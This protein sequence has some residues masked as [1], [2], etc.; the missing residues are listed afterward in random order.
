MTIDDPEL[1]EEFLNEAREHLELVES[2]LL[3]LETAEGD[4]KP[5]LNTIFR[6]MHSIKGAAGMLGFDQMRDLTHA[7]E[8]VLSRLR[9]GTQETDPEIVSALLTATDSVKGM[10]ENI[11]GEPSSDISTE[12]A[13]LEALDPSRRAT[14]A[15]TPEP[16]EPAPEPEPES[17]PEPAPESTPEPD[18]T[19][20]D[21][22]PADATPATVADS[23]PSPAPAANDAGTPANAAK[24]GARPAGA[25]GGAQQ[26]V[27]GQ[28][29]NETVRVPVWV[30]D[31]LMALT[32]ELVLVRNRTLQ[33][34]DGQLRRDRSL[35]GSVD[36]R[37]AQQ[38]DLVT[39]DLQEAVLRTR[40]QPVGKVFSRIPRLC[41]DLA[42][43]LDKQ[44]SCVTLGDDVEVDKTILE[45]LSDP[46]IHLVRNACDHGLETPDER[47][48]TGKSH[49]GVVQIAAR[50]DAGQI[51]ITIKD[52]GRGIDPK[53]IGAKAI[54]VGLCRPDEIAAMT[55]KQI[56]NLIFAPGFSTA[57]EVGAISGRGVG[58]DVVK[59]SIEGIGGSL[60]VVSEVGRGSTFHLRVPLTL[61]IVSSLV[62]RT[63]GK[64]FAIPQVNLEE[65]VRLDDEEISEGIE[66]VN[67]QPIYRLRSALLPLVYL[68]DVLSYRDGIP[69]DASLRPAHE[70]A[71]GGTLTFA[72]V[73][74]GDLR[75]GIV[76]DEAIGS[77]EIVVK[78]NHPLLHDLRCFVGSTILGDGSVALI[79]DVNGVAQHAAVDRRFAEASQLE[80]TARS[81]GVDLQRDLLL[82][83]DG[84]DRFLV[85]LSLVAR[86]VPIPRTALQ[87][88]GDVTMVEIGGHNVRV[89]MLDKHM[90]TGS[91]PQDVEDYLLVLP[92]NFQHSVGFLATRVLDIYE[93]PPPSETDLHDH[94]AVLGS[95]VIDGRLAVYLDLFELARLEQP[96]RYLEK[97]KVD[98]PHR[99]VLLVDDVE[100]FRKAV[101]RYLEQMGF[102]VDVAVDG[103]EA[104]SRLGAAGADY[105]LLVSDLEMPELDGF[106]L[107]D[108]LRRRPPNP[109]MGKIPALA[110]SALPAPEVRDRALARGFDEF[111]LKL[112]KTGL[113]DAIARITGWADV[114]EVA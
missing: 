67:S 13:M 51:E 87:H 2:S 53:K 1:V 28:N 38:L 47:V 37:L 29:H 17:E 112:E 71:E 25:D 14:K 73:R 95:C 100:F 60:D 111:E 23:S 4:L 39:S 90:G 12:V 5:V 88:L 96:E 86:V 80:S 36:R 44:I 99:R 61:A 65:I 83:V 114:A 31:R 75:F 69:D 102:A 72:V 81:S 77:E 106:G 85:S 41:R 52:D 97:R 15:A 66:Y 6:A 40:M 11:A 74:V 93:G 56:C 22:T 16:L 49:T 70:H 34:L 57:E 105:D 58:M 32:G 68:H 64:L 107:I 91:Y 45:C 113:A 82:T 84:N 42:R 109:A 78:P 110:L 101:G 108:E 46:L 10:V 35:V 62:V 33:H 54:S 19:P 50:H 7:A 27:A 92:R 76:V 24:P 3:A 8:T 104:L 21:A 98:R 63:S 43:K 30:L 18:A 26:A 94:R 48:A 20:S 55:P 103:R 89:I 9:E 79:L 59:T